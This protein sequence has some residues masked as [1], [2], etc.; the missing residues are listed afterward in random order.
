M[1]LTSILQGTHNARELSGF[2]L[3]GG[4]T[5]AS[6]LL[7]RSDALAALTDE[8]MQE[9]VDLRIGTV[10]DLRTDGERARAADRLPDDGSVTLLPLPMQGGAMDEMVKHLLP[11]ARGAGLSVTQVAEALKQVPTLEQ[12]YVSILE[13]SATPFATVARTVLAASRTD[14]PGVLFHCT[15]GKDRTGLAAAILLSVAGVPRE[16]IVEDYTQTEKNL[17]LGLADALTL[18]ITSLGVP[19]TPGLKTLATE[20]PAS[21]IEAALDWIA[22]NHG[23]VADY[24][25]SGGMDDAEIADLRRVLRGE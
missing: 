13:G 3:T 9:L 18:L 15:A 2:P 7:F 22:A 10:I 4:G 12:L 16:V 5:L 11:S 25:R 14:R 17:A 23:D 21:A 6:G 8:G 24:L 19:L 20:S 1:E